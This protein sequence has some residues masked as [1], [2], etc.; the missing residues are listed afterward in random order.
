MVEKNIV[1][2][3][4][5]CPAFSFTNRTETKAFISGIFKNEKFKLASVR[6]IFCSDERLRDMNEQFLKH[7]D[8]TDILTFPLS[9]KGEPISGEIYIS[10]DRVRDNSLI[11][12]TN[13]R[14]ELLRVLFHG[15]LHLCQYLDHTEK[16][17][18]KMRAREDFYLDL[19]KKILSG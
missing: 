5:D 19:F 12:N 2:F 4:Y 3:F 16:E 1:Q 11:F 18:R 9:G 17:I 10:I 14:T 6:Y 7:T 15:A 13:F 8:Y